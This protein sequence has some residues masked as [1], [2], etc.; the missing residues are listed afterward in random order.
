MFFDGLLS[1]ICHPLNGLSGFAFAALGH[2]E[3]WTGKSSVDMGRLQS[4]LAC[5]WLSARSGNWGLMTL[6]RHAAGTHGHQ[7]PYI[8]LMMNDGSLQYYHDASGTHA[9]DHP[10]VGCSSRT[11]VWQGPF[12]PCVDLGTVSPCRTQVSVSLVVT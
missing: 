1:P 2:S 4:R 7:H 12:V 5:A 6:S 11:R 9:V 10:T 8:S 3:R